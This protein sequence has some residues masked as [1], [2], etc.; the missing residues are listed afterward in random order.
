MAK[1]R[2]DDRA[3]AKG[4]SLEGLQAEIVRVDGLIAAESDTDV[5]AAHKRVRARLAR[6]VADIKAAAKLK[7]ELKIA[8]S[9]SEVLDNHGIPFPPVEAYEEDRSGR[10]DGKKKRFEWSPGDYEVIADDVVAELV[11]REVEVFFRAG[12]IVEISQGGQIVEV[13]TVRMRE[14]VSR[15]C[16]FMRK[17]EGGQFVRIMVPEQL[18]KTICSRPDPGLRTLVAVIR[19]PTLRHTDGSILEAIGFDTAT[20]LYYR[21]DTMIVPRIPQRP[22]LE[23]AKQ[24][25]E[26]LLKP[27]IDF[28]FILPAHQE[29]ALAYLMTCVLRSSIDDP[30]PGFG[31]DAPDPGTGKSLLAK[32]GGWIS[33]GRDP[34]SE[35]YIK[36]EEEQEKR[37]VASLQAGRPIFMWDNIDAPFGSAIIDMILTSRHF[38][39]RILGTSLMAELI[40]N[41]VW[42]FN[43]N[44]LRLKNIDSAR[45]LVWVRMKD[46]KGNPTIRTG[47][48]LGGPPELKRWV[49]QNRAKLVQACLIIARWGVLNRSLT[50]GLK[51]YASFEAWS[52]LIRRPLWYLSEGIDLLDGKPTDPGMHEESAYVAAFISEWLAIRGREND[53]MNPPAPVSIAE[54]LNDKNHPR[55]TLKDIARELAPGS[56]H[57]LSKRLGHVISRWKQRAIQVQGPDGQSWGSWTIVSG[58]KSYKGVVYDLIQVE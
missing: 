30:T 37:I 48:A 5:V 10:D 55:D 53:L 50:D 17:E 39:G 7:P 54:L 40:N 38:T 14:I 21:R 33:L 23:L 8:S 13:D 34:H 19:A 1:R 25:R 42:C 11:E 35:G 28:P 4:P 3:P 51:P 56:D 43:G 27:L 26:F 49:L 22:S 46:P 52:D 12:Q 36:V 31:F 45:R 15:H 16:Q 20:A 32:M 24:A 57:T 29:V 44:N 58:E 6:Q 41:C 18:S 9:A 2:G 47:F